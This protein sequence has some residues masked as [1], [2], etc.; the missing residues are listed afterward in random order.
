MDKTFIKRVEN[1]EVTREEILEYCG[2][3]KARME[4]KEKNGC[5][6]SEETL[7]LLICLDCIWEM[8]GTNYEETE[9]VIPEA[10]KD[11]PISDIPVTACRQCLEPM[12]ETAEQ[13]ISTYKAYLTNKSGLVFK[14]LYDAY[15]PWHEM[16]MYFSDRLMDYG[17]WIPTN[18]YP[19]WHKYFEKYGELSFE[20]TM[21]VYIEGMLFFLNK[22][23]EALES[24]DQS[25]CMALFP[26]MD[27]LRNNITFTLIREGK[28]YEQKDERG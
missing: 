13:F 25:M 22:A 2:K 9:E 17:D 16:E 19:E 21:E 20:E 18:D 15:A 10:I 23:E 8:D 27:M 6:T 26:S 1:R 12:R 4:L 7:E 5:D 28:K 14:Q 24:Y 11:V 3:V